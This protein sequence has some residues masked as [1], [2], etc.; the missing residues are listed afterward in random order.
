ML[1]GNLIAL[2]AYISN[3]EK[4]WIN[5]LSFYLKNLEIENQNEPKQAEGKK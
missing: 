4:S 1:R 2:N 5:H 3:E